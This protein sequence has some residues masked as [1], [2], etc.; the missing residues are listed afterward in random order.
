MVRTRTVI[1]GGGFGGLEAAHHLCRKSTEIILIDKMNHH[2]FQP[3]L[4]QVATA[5]LSPI[6]IATPLRQIFKG[7]ENFT[8]IMATVTSINKDLRTVTLGDGTVIEFDNLIVATGAHHSYFGKNQFEKFAPGLKTLEDGTRICGN[9]LTAFEEAARA[10]TE[11]EMK[12]LL[13]FV[14]IGGGPTGV[15]LAGAIA[16]IAFEALIKNYRNVNLRETE[17]FLIEGSGRLLP[18]FPE[19]LSEKAKAAL[20]KLG[21]TVLLNSMVS[22][23]NE[24]GVFVQGGRCIETQNIIWAAGNQASPLVKTLDIPLDRQGRAIVDKD[25]SIPNY[26][27][28]FVIGDTAC[29]YDDAGVSY[30]ALAPVAK[31][32]GKFVAEIISKNIPKNLRPRYHYHDKGSLA[33]IG[34][35]KAVGLIGKMQVSGFFAWLT[36]SVVHIAYLI[37]FRNR[38][39]VLTQWLFWYLRGKRRVQLITVPIDEST[40][41]FK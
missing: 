6:D 2:L 31:Q 40:L 5:A 23:V 15:E 19:K 1:I 8:F 24:K 28:I 9:I 26:P 37:G 12:R 21:V 20:E 10:K 14:V 29:C 16:E 33:T 27:N 4:Y 17:V 39:F 25:L 13:R 3:L 41:D 7:Q 32:Q 11:E 36:W 18:M 34:R 30:P 38:L 35:G 22:D